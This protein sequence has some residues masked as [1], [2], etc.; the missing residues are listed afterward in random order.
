MTSP[1]DNDVLAGDRPFDETGELAL[2][3]VD[4]NF[5]AAMLA[6]SFS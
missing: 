5:H 2:G 6:K 1:G 4:V 3:F